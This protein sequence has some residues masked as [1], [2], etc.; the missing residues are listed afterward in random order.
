MAREEQDLDHN[1]DFA[2]GMPMVSV[3]QRVQAILKQMSEEHGNAE[4]GDPTPELWAIAELL[5]LLVTEGLP[6]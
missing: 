6:S 4:R 3:R 1:F 5:A 2:N